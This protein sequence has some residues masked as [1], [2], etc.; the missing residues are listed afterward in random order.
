MSMKEFYTRSK[1]NEGKKVP[2]SLPDGSPSEHWLVIR[3]V[4][5]DEFRRAEAKSKR[6]AIEIAQIKN[7]QERDAAIE[8]QKLELIAVLVAGWSFEEECTR[9]NVV[10]FLREAPQIADMVDRIAVSRASF[11]GERSSS[12]TGTQKKS[13]DSKSARKAPKSR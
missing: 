1:A 3:G 6:K 11:F 5:S 2:L 13:S 9:D 8:Q 7:D 12:S 4:D 10:D